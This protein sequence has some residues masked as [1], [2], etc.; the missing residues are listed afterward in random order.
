MKSFPM[1]PMSFLAG[2]TKLLW[3]STGIIIVILL[4]IAGWGYVNRLKEPV[5]NAENAIPDDVAWYLKLNKAKDLWPRIHDENDIYKELRNIPYFNDAF[6]SVLSLDSITRADADAPELTAGQAVFICCRYNKDKLA[7][8]LILMNLPDAH[9]AGTVKEIFA[10]HLAQGFE[11]KEHESED[12]LIFDGTVNGHTAFVSAVSKGIFMFSPSEDFIESALKQL[13]GNIP[14]NADKVFSKVHATT[15]K[16]VDG[17]FFINLHFLSTLLNNI[18]DS[19]YTDEKEFLSLTGSWAGLDLILKKDEIF[20]NGYIDAAEKDYLAV[21]R[22]KKPQKTGITHMIPFNTALMLYFGADDLRKYA[23]DYSTFLTTNGFT[24]GENELQEINTSCHC[25]IKES[26]LSWMGNEMA[27]VITESKAGDFNSNTYGIFRAI[28]MPKTKEQLE[29]ISTSAE[30]TG[31]SEGMNNEFVIRKINCK[32]FLQEIF[33]K[34]FANLAE[35]YYFILGDYVVFG[36]SPQALR[37]FISAY[38]SNKTLDKNENYKA[39]ADNVSENASICLYINIRK[40]IEL[41]KRFANP[42]FRE[43]MDPYT[44]RLRNFQAFAIQIAPDKDMFYANVYLKYNPGYKD[45]NPAVWE[46]CLDTTVSGRPFLITDIQDSSRKV[47]VFDRM[48][49]M[50]L[51]DDLGRI[52]WKVKLAEAPLSDLFVIDRYHNRKSQIIFNTTH[53]VFMLDMNGKYAPGFPVTLPLPATNGLKVL[54]YENKKDYRILL[55]C[56]DHKLYN[57]TADGKKT[58]GWADPFIGALVNDPVAHVKMQGKDYLI[59]ADANGICHFYDRRGNASFPKCKEAF[60]KSKY[61]GFFVYSDKEKSRIITTDRKGRIIRIAPDGKWDAIML[62]DFSPEHKFLYAD[63]DGNTINDY[64]F[65]D[66]STVTVYD[67]NKKIIF[68]L[69]IPGQI[70]TLP[71]KTEASSKKPLFGLVTGNSG[72]IYLFSMKGLSPINQFLYGSTPFCTGRFDKGGVPS[73]I[74]AK[75]KTVYNYYLT[76]F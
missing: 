50:Y 12:A 49:Q 63:F 53:Q 43:Q 31:K 19:A 37:V 34:I 75:D 28:N 74:V 21:F 35:N 18:T 25:D 67:V 56:D 5:V 13:K 29:A 70:T 16:N 57:F 59:I 60:I 76:G 40:S 48:N 45:E 6:S 30:S 42:L 33:G 22:G 64:I 44:S 24:N 8:Y 51:I 66:D 17:N 65:A 2:K 15:G 7:E 47:V 54:D 72:R 36:N 71:V 23:D 11:L 39:F 20:L 10:R 26:M 69:D 58:N 46:A 14:L 9:E 68:K 4:I 1:K 32:G 27:L 3:I 73:L 41:I 52:K 61:S 62:K 55:V 38:V